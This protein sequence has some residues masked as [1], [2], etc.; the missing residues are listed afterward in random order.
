MGRPC[1]TNEGEEEAY[2]ILVEKPEEKRP[3]GR[4][5]CRRVGSITW[6]LER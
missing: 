3:L 5:R 4:P 6:I 2:M 1:S